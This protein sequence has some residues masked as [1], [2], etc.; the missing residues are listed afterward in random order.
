MKPRKPATCRGC[1]RELVGDDYMYG[2]SAW[3]PDTKERCPTNHYGGFV[4]SPRCDR[5]AS[6]TLENSM[7]GHLSMDTTLS[8]FAEKA[9]ER[10]WA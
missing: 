7:P 9:L 1:R 10:N 6:Q 3:H 2:G 5:E 4:C 8:S